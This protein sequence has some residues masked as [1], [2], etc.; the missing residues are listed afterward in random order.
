MQT[1]KYKEIIP[2]VNNNNNNNNVSAVINNEDDCIPI[3]Y[4][5]CNFLNIVYSLYMDLEEIPDCNLSN[6]C[7]KF[8]IP[9]QKITIP[10]GKTLQIN[11]DIEPQQE[12]SIDFKSLGYKRI[13]YFL[14]QA[15]CGD[16]IYKFSD[17]QNWVK[18]RT[19]F[20]DLTDYRICCDEN[21][22]VSKPV[23]DSEFYSFYP[24]VTLKNYFPKKGI[25]IK[26]DLLIKNI[27]VYLVLVGF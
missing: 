17:C 26:P 8:I 12:I 27:R 18:A 20:Q 1:I 14:L 23:Y 2:K 24:T 7:N 3:S 10:D 9:P 6:G 22:F 5:S 25:F 16:F 19:V 13:L 15:K 4:A 21:I 11:Y